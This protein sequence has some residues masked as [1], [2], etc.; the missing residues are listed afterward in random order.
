MGLWSVGWGLAVCLWL[1]PPWF[2]CWF[3][4]TLTCGGVG[5]GCSSLFVV[6]VGLVFVFSLWCF[7]WVRGPC[8]GR[9]F[10]F[11]FFLCVSVLRVAFGPR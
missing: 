11:F 4:F 6:V 7:G 8:A 9:V 10:F 1:G 2:G 3:S 5:R